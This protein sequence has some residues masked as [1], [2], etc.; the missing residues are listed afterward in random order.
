MPKKGIKITDTVANP[1]GGSSLTAMFACIKSVQTHWN[2]DRTLTAQIIIGLFRNEA[3]C[4]S[5]L[6]QLSLPSVFNVSLTQSEWEASG[7]HRD[8]WIDK[9]NTVLKVTVANGG[10]GYTS[11]T[12]INY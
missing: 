9:L 1:H 2:A 11:T 3:D 7:S 10:G 4:D 8:F 5:E 12:I 6:E